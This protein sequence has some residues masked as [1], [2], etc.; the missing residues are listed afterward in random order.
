MNTDVSIDSYQKGFND[1]VQCDEPRLPMYVIKI[2][3]LNCVE[4]SATARQRKEPEFKHL[5]SLIYGRA[6]FVISQVVSTKA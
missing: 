1:T 6:D 3:Q 4:S 5:L 2:I